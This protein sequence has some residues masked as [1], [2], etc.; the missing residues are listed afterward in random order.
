VKREQSCL[1][2]FSD[3]PLHQLLLLLLSKS[4]LIVVWQHLLLNM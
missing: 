2:N 4:S 1:A 3:K